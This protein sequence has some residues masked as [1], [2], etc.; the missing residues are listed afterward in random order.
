MDKPKGSDLRSRLST[1]W[2]RHWEIIIAAA[3]AFIV[4]GLIVLIG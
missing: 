3:A 4:S 2:A 1:I